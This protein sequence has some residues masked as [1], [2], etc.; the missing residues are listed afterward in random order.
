MDHSDLIRHKVGEPVS[1]PIVLTDDTLQQVLASAR[2]TWPL[3]MVDDQTFLQFLIE[4]IPHE[5]GR[6]E[7]LRALHT[8]DLYLV[9]GCLHGDLHALAAVESQYLSQL[10]ASVA[11]SD[12]GSGFMDELKQSL[13]ERV[14]VAR[15]DE[16]PRIASYSGRGP[17]AGWLRMVAARL[18]I[19]LRK[20][21]KGQ[22][23][24]ADADSL[25]VPVVDLEL[26]YLK[27]RYRAEFESA[28]QSA[29]RELPARERALLR[30]H[31]VDGVALSSIATMYGVSQRT[32]QRWIAAAHVAI[33]AGVRRTLVA[34]FALTEGELDSLL[35]LVISQLSVTLQDL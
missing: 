24:T 27:E 33:K 35:G 21:Q 17:L 22:V 2:A 15:H 34:K 13:R 4:R 14:L 25:A 3:V 5:G 1:L 26:Q 16:P 7:S 29:F 31:S 11:A 6:D 23:A 19:D 28:I 9:C 20:K 32:V 18:A 8:S 10:G 30:L 12:A